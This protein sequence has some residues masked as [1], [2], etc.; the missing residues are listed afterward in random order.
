MLMGAVSF[1]NISANSKRQAASGLHTALVEADVSMIIS[2]VFS[3]EIKTDKQI[4]ISVYQRNE[5]SKIFLLE[6]GGG[7][8]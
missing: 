8:E 7:R 5:R 2:F 6:T 1:R 3:Q 4:T